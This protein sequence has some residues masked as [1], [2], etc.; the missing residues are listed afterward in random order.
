MRFQGTGA[1]ILY[2]TASLSAFSHGLE[3]CHHSSSKGIS[4]L[5][6]LVEYPSC[7][8]SSAD[9]LRARHTL[10][11]LS[12]PKPTATGDEKGDKNENV[13]PPQ[14]SGQVGGGKIENGAII[15]ENDTLFPSFEEWK[16]Q[17]MDQTQERVDDN[18]AGDVD[19]VKRESSSSPGGVTETP[20]EL[21]RIV[22]EP[23]AD[24]ATNG[25][26]TTQ[27]IIPD[28][29]VYKDRFNFASFDCAATIMK[30]NADTKGASNILVENKDTYMLNRCSSENKFVI[31]ELCQDILVDTVAI[32][33]YEFFSSMFR[34]IRISVSDRF[35][36]GKAG[37]KEL[38]E[39]EAASVRDLQF[40]HIKNPLIW[41]RYVRIDFVSHWGNEFFCPVS[42]VRIHGTTM[43]DEYRQK[44][45]KEEQPEIPPSKDSTAQDENAKSDGVTQG[46]PVEKDYPQTDYT[47]K[48]PAH[49]EDGI[50]DQEYCDN[51]YDTIKHGFNMCMPVSPLILNASYCWDVYYDNGSKQI[52]PPIT[53]GS[54]YTVQSSSEPRTQDSIYQTIMK[55]LSFLESNATLSLKY[56]EQQSQNL[57]DL[58]LKIEKNQ[59]VRI[60]SFFSEFN[61]SVVAQLEQ[62][63]QQY[64]EL[65]LETVGDMQHRKTKNE[66][67]LS[68]LNSR[69]NMLADELVYQKKLG[70]IQAVILLTVLAFVIATRGIAVDSYALSMIND[71]GSRLLQRMGMSVPSSP[72]A[73]PRRGNFFGTDSAI[74]QAPVHAH[75]D[76]ELHAGTL[77]FSEE[78]SPSGQEDSPRTVDF[79][80]EEDDDYYEASDYDDS[81]YD[82]H[83][84]EVSYIDDYLHKSHD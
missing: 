31:I 15:G 32:A 50:E 81:D 75:S 51:P 16:K 20:A 5:R 17:N 58:L 47:I 23:Q 14:D 10:V 26:A 12:R 74:I 38:G 73:T 35:P 64:N 62:F 57:R 72:V 40:F 37:W 63:Q 53:P 83:D 36:V 34:H 48:N 29:K 52:P 70:F 24:P 27:T 42:L 18:Q 77:G 2:G 41:S 68:T 13:E 69:V 21:E 33:N 46:A 66:H 82:D 65:L 8:V 28:G 6:D 3:S 19:P 54:N 45:E 11:T 7:P 80:K 4:V 22:V 43:M 39:F 44:H 61:S 76:S 30:T 71:R 1:A 59:N 67:D 84:Y 78:E 60:E 49:S 56:I 55:R 79:E 9:A 25:V